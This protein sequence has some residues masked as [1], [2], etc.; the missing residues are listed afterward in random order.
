MGILPD[1]KPAVQVPEHSK[2]EG[3]N[4]QEGKKKHNSKVLSSPYGSLTYISRYNAKSSG[5]KFKKKVQQLNAFGIFARK[6]TN[7]ENTPKKVDS[8][9]N[10]SQVNGGN[11]EKLTSDENDKSKNGMD[12]GNVKSKNYSSGDNGEKSKSN[13]KIFNEPSNW[14]HVKSRLFDPNANT[15]NTLKTSPNTTRKLK[16]GIDDDG[17]QKT[18][19]S[20][21]KIRNAVKIFNSSSDYSHVKSRLFDANA[22]QVNS[23]NL[24]KPSS[25][26]R[27]K[28]KVGIEDDA[29]ISG[30]ELSKRRGSV[31][32]FNA[33]SDY[34]HIKSKLFDANASSSRRSSRVIPQDIINDVQNKQGKGQEKEDRVSKTSN[35]IKIFNAPSDY[36]HVKSK[37]FDADASSNRRSPQVNPQDI[38]NVQNKQ[39]NEKGQEKENQVSKISNNIKIFNAPSDYSHVKS[40]LYDSSNTAKGQDHETSA[41]KVKNTIVGEQDT[42]NKKA[43]T[44]V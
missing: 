37:L 39:E 24:L 25:N 7:D 13:V 23:E 12:E 6:P 28:S 4:T 22:N 1:T 34:S 5:G 15:Q 32:I 19:N 11:E 29:A 20:D 44:D 26:I 35:N 31:K 42:Q 17:D 30:D 9:S 3:E 2:E 40:R 16:V 21:E 38:N 41:L 33:P 36:S 18:G 10:E 43:S 14:S 8:T 27:R